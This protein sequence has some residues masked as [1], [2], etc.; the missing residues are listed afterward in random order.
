ME[1]RPPLGTALQGLDFQLLTDI[2][3]LATTALSMMPIPC[4]V[5]TRTARTCPIWRPFSILSNP[6]Q[7]N[8]MPPGSMPEDFR[9]IPCFP[10]TLDSVSTKRFWEFGREVVVLLIPENCPI[11]Q[12][13]KAKYVLDHFWPF[14]PDDKKLLISRNFID[15]CLWLC[16]MRS[17]WYQM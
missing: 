15:F 12:D 7:I 11:Y 4:P 5:P 1:M 10:L 17:R 9:K 6:T 8:L 14:S 16:S 13:V 3:H 2:G